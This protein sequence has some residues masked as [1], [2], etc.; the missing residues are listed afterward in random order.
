VA[1][2]VVQP[3]SLHSRGLSDSRDKEREWERVYYYHYVI[4]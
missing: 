4:S 1:V 3:N 2:A